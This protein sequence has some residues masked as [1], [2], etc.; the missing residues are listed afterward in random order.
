MQAYSNKRISLANQEL[1]RTGAYSS[2]YCCKRLW[3]R[4]WLL[5]LQCRIVHHLRNYFTDWVYLLSNW[6]IKEE[7]RLKKTG[8]RTQPKKR[9]LS[10]VWGEETTSSW[11]YITNTPLL[12][13]QVSIGPALIACTT[14]PYCDPTTK[15]LYRLGVSIFTQ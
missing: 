15:L 14:M 5:V 1:N 6:C 7:G 2:Y 13:L 4:H 9:D 8:K 12:L 3:D 11:W 10:D